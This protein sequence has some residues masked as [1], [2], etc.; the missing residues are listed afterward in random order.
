MQARWVPL[1]SLPTAKTLSPGFK[2]ASTASGV[3]KQRRTKR[4]LHKYFFIEDI[5]HSGLGG[6]REIPRGGAREIPGYLH[7]FPIH[8]SSFKDGQPTYGPRPSIKS[9]SQRAA[10]YGPRNQV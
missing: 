3:E 5:S 1:T 10:D 7:N 8:T 6:A 4:P 9:G 2:A